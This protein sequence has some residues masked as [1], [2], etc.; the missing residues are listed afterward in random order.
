[1]K[2]ELWS[3]LQVTANQVIALEKIRIA[4]EL[5]I[6]QYRQ[7]GF[8]DILITPLLAGLDEVRVNEGKLK[9]ECAKAVKK[10]REEE[11][12]NS[13]P[14]FGP[15]VWLTL[16]SLP[17]QPGEYRTVSGLWKTLGLHV[18]E[19]AAVKRKGGDSGP[20]QR[21]RQELRA[22]ALYRVGKS[23]Q[24]LKGGEDKNGKNMVRSPYRDIYDRRKMATLETHPPMLKE[25]EGCVVC[26]TAYEKSRTSRAKSHQTRERQAVGADC[27]NLG[28]I[29]W[30]DG[31]RH[32][33]ALRVMT[34]AIFR[35]IWRVWRG[36]E[37]KYAG[38]ST[39][40]QDQAA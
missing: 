29:H 26:D 19:G 18:H 25:G 20:H 35:D 14:G 33:D 13:V 9:R 23:H 12:I 38:E 28:G 31:H 6:W 36:M 2:E 3:S 27:A 39:T 40:V 34:K 16:G 1:M 15:A 24:M 8:P 11:W 37:P 17:I 4:T 7:R 5:R 32:S 30:T 10:T 21:F 22:F